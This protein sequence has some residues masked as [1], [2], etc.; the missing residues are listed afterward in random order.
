[1]K[2]MK[3]ILVFEWINVDVKKFSLI[4]EFV[5]YW[6]QKFSLTLELYVQNFMFIFE[7]GRH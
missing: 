7:F 2:K 6:V 5:D 1:M 4:L 3:C